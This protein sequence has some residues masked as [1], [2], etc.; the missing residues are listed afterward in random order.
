MANAMTPP[1]RAVVLGTGTEVGKTQVSVALLHGVVAY[2]SSC[3]GLK[4][5]ESGARDV[6]EDAC[7]LANA[8]GH[9]Y[10]PPRYALKDPVSPHLAAEREGVR[11]ELEDVG[12]WVREHE[13]AKDALTLI[14]TAGGAFSPITLQLT[15][16][17]LAIS[18]EPACW[19]LVVGNRLGCLHDTLAC[20][21]ALE[22]VA[23]A[24]DVIVLNDVSATPDQATP[25]NLHELRRL[26]LGM[27]IFHHPHGE[28]VNSDL[29][30]WV[31]RQRL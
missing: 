18:L 31:T 7:A 3:R 5:I 25:S 9:P 15:N 19:I 1:P 29:A 27:E 8:A 14:E 22:A 24:P 11:V 26:Q 17:D 13:H 4:P 10:A 6:A 12:S 23:R 16:A 2:G 30:R 20:V 28:H 21:R